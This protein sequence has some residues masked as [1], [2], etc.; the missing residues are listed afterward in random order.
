MSLANCSADLGVS[1]NVAQCE[2]NQGIP[3]VKAAEG[4][5]PKEHQAGSEHDSQQLK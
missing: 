2:N 5:A 3:W 4:M 1:L